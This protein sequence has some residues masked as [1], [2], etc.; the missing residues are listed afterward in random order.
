LLRP[1]ETRH[2]Q[3]TPATARQIRQGRWPPKER[4]LH[5]RAAHKTRG[6]PKR[7]RQQNCPTESLRPTR[8][9][10]RTHC[11][12]AVPST[13]ITPGCAGETVQGDRCCLLLSLGICGAWWRCPASS[14]NCRNCCLFIDV[15]AEGGQ[16]NHISATRLTGRRRGLECGVIMAPMSGTNRKHRQPLS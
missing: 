1:W 11:A 5:L 13:F 14:H 15:R 6:A 10:R 9:T 7:S 8:T 16:G 12:R 4:A 2:R 3:R